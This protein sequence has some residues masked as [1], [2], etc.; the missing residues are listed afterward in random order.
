MSRKELRH[1]DMWF[2]APVS[3]YHRE[4]SRFASASS[5]AKTLA[6]T[7]RISRRCGGVG[8]SAF[9]RLG[10]TVADAIRRTSSDDSSW[11]WATWA[12][13]RRLLR[14]SLVQWL[15]RRQNLQ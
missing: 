15:G 12:S 7:T 6:S 2:V 9:L 5:W 14:Q 8:G 1:P 10:K 4:S 3:R 11:A 13:A